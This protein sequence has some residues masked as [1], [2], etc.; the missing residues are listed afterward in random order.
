MKQFGAPL[1]SENS[2]AGIKLTIEVLHKDFLNESVP[3]SDD[4]SIYAPTAAISKFTAAEIT[5]QQFIDA[6]VVMVNGNRIEV[7]PSR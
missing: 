1:A 6:C 5:N 3:D 4:V 2:L 7:A